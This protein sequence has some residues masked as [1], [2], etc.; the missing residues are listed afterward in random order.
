MI[1]AKA[2]D[3]KLKLNGVELPNDLK[4]Y[5]SVPTISEEPVVASYGGMYVLLEITPQGWGA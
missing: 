1:H 5:I 2:K 4:S 3:V